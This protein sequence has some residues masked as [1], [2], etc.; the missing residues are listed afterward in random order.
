MSRA[1]ASP[2][3]RACALNPDEAALRFSRLMNLDRYSFEFGHSYALA[4]PGM[5]APMGVHRIQRTRLRQIIMDQL[6]RTGRL[7]LV[8]E[9]LDL[10]PCGVGYTH[11]AVDET[12]GGTGGAHWAGDSSKWSQE[13]KVLSLHSGMRAQ[14]EE[15][16]HAMTK[17]GF[18]PTIFFGW[19]SVA[20]QLEIFKKK[21]TRVKFSFHNVQKNDGSPDAYAADIVDRRWAWSDQARQH[22]FWK[23]LGEE[24]KNQNLH[25]GGDWKKP[26]WAHVQL[27]PNSQLKRL[28]RASGL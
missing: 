24:A 13:K 10:P 9:G 22:G 3:H 1:R 16:I 6:S 25:W 21:H 11:G 5:P 14:V 23:A 20:A 12:H 7:I 26:D 18:Q 2:F 4:A 8:S 27:V 28:K 17:R 15:V 19:R